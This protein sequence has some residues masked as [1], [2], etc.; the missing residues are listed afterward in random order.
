MFEYKPDLDQTMQRMEAFWE[1]SV[2]DRPVTQFSLEKPVDEQIPVP[3]SRHTNPSARWL[4]VEYQ[5]EL[6]DAQLYNQQFLGDS[7]PVAF[8]NLG[9]EIL[10]AFYGCQLQFGDYGTSWS[11][12][13]LEDW[14]RVVESIIPAW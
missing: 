1:G 13:I 8:P 14:A 6:A 11:K 2:L 3:E 12:P 10:A 7:L 5:A 9:P 4:D